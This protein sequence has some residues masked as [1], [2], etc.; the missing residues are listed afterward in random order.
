MRQEAGYR[1]TR[2]FIQASERICAA[3]I[4]RDP[5]YQPETDEIALLSCKSEP[6]GA[7]QEGYVRN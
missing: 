5:K 3:V 2:G 6:A 1:R 4:L 7:E